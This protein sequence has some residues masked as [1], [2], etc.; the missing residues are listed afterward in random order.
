VTTPCDIHKIIRLRAAAVALAV[1]AAVGT[2]ARGQSVGEQAPFTPMGL[3]GA[4][5][6]ST[7]SRLGPAPGTDAGPFAAQP[8]Q[9]QPLMGAGGA[10]S[11]P[12]VPA[13]ISTPEANPTAGTRSMAAPTPLP[14][15]P[16]QLYGSLSMPEEDE[17]AAVPGGMTLDQA[18]ELMIRENLDLKSKALEIPQARADVL[19]ASLLANPIFFADAQMVPYGN[20]TKERPGGQT[21][22]DVNISHP[23]D[24]S[25]KRTARKAYAS[26]VVRVVEAQYQDAVRLAMQNVHTAFVDVLSARQLARYAKASVEGFDRLIRATE[27]LYERDISSRADVS[28]VKSQQQIAIVGL[29]DAEENLRRS[30]RTLGMLLNIPPEQA[31]TLEFDG[32][33]EDRGPEP[34]P[35]EELVRMA[36]EFRPDVIAFRLGIKAAEAGYGLAR[37]NRYQDA[38]VLYQPYTFQNNAP[39]GL[40]S[41]YSW[42]LGVTVP[43]PLYNRN[44]GNIERARLNINQSRIDLA[45]IERRVE[46]EVVQAARE[47]QI[48]RD[49]VKRIRTEIIPASEQSK[50]DRFVLFQNSQVNVVSYLDAQRVH[51]DNVKAYLDT[52]IRHRRS[53]LNLDTVVGRRLLP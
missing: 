53:M 39:I 34:P 26:Q 40:K 4:A 10:T 16:A 30:K 2:T 18:I 25:F 52:A 21:Q 3:G 28:Q 27:L 24:F 20:Y 43:M 45:A 6:G 8:G 23:V 47:Y 31:E 5:P 22:Y 37:A 32:V 1:A 14:V 15:P 17:A 46:T 50:N 13:S 51:N 49:I 48:T 41:A 12:R 33:I 44:Q 29:E 38:Y 42:A 7:Q 9:D 19:T 11:V 36:L 35:T